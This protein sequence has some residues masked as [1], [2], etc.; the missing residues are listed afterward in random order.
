[1][2][3]QA[4]SHSQTCLTQPLSLPASLGLAA[5]IL[6]PTFLKDGGTGRVSWGP[7]EG[8]LALSSPYRVR[9]RQGTYS[10]P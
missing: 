8:T 9:Q 5:L 7:C 10:D 2:K 4:T 6:P 1:M 3:G